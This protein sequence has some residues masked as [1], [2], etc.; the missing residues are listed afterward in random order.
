MR[1]RQAKTTLCVLALSHK[2]IVNEGLM[3]TWVKARLRIAVG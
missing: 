2:V 3:R 1:R